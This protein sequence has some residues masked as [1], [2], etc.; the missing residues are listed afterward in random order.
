MCR[1]RFPIEGLGSWSGA[2]T[3]RADNLDVFQN[4]PA[5]P[6]LALARPRLNHPMTGRAIDRRQTTS[7]ITSG[8]R[9]GP[10]AQAKVDALDGEENRLKRRLGAILEQQKAMLEEELRDVKRQK[11]NLVQRREN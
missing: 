2:A 1:F 8:T 3:Q 7:T 10:N 9:T 6:L 5:I 4:S 11:A